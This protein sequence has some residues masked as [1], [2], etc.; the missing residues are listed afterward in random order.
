[1]KYIVFNYTDGIPGPFQKKFTSRKAA[2]EAIKEWRAR[3]NQAQ[4]Y[5]RTSRGDRIDVEHVDL[6]IEE[7]NNNPKATFFN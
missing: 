2:R 3:M 7:A 4:G 6:E 5:Y 1:M